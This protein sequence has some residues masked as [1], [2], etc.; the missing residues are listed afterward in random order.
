MN[1]KKIVW[2][3]CLTALIPIPSAAFAV[4]LPD[5]PQ[6][7]KKAPVKEIPNPEKTAR[8]RTDEMDKVLN[9]TEKQYKKIYKLNLKEEREKLEA[10]IGRGDRDTGCPPM[11]GGG[12]PPMRH[13]DGE[14]PM[15]DGGSQPPMMGH[16][17]RPMMAPPADNDKMKDD[18]RE[19]TEKKMKK[20]RKILTDEQYDLWLTMKPEP[21]P[22]PAD[23]APVL[24]EEAPQFDMIQNEAEQ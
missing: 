13:S 10:L 2:I 3:F 21:R 23:G 6:Q 12:R 4:A 8:K 22:E 14:P 20:I 5:E 9:L 16:G 7:E 18:I 19:R 15:M 1:M 24:P 17:R 11:M